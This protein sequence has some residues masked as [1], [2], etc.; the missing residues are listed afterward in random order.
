MVID[1]K[2]IAAD[3]NSDNNLDVLDIIILIIFI[4][5]WATTP[6]NK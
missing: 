4:I 3:L 2:K 5:G 6:D 1:G